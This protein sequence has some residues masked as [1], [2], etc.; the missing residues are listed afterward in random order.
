MHSLLQHSL[1]SWLQSKVRNSSASF[2][3]QL[4]KFVANSDGYP[5]CGQAYYHRCLLWFSFNRNV[6][7]TGRLFLPCFLPSYLPLDSVTDSV[8]DLVYYPCTTSCIYNLFSL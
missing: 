5:E 8:T 1:S 6:S 2:F 7:S 4:H 3:S